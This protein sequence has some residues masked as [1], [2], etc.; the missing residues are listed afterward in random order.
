MNVK[1]LDEGN[2][3]KHPIMGCYGIGVDRTIASVIEQSY[4]ANGIIFPITIAPFEL[5]MI[6]II[7][8]NKE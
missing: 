8:D 3:E 6:P 1:F 2:K 4:D 7:K 5:M